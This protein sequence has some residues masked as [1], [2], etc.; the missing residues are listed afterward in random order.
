MVESKNHGDNSYTYH[1]FGYFA[2]P[3]QM[4]PVTILPTSGSGVSLSADEN[5][6]LLKSKYPGDGYVCLKRIALYGY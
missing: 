3:P 5:R 1:N 6:V 4:T 2:G